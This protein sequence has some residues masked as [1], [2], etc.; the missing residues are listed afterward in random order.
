MNLFSDYCKA[1]FSVPENA[2][3]T[4]QLCG[5]LCKLVTINLFGIRSSGVEILSIRLFHNPDIVFAHS[6]DQGVARNAE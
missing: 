1:I 2:Q 4:A 5:F 6:S 3:E